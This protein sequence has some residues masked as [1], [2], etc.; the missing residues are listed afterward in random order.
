M[1]RRGPSLK[2]GQDKAH[3]GKDKM[4]KVLWSKYNALK[5]RV[6]VREGSDVKIQQT[7]W[8]D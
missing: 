7:L 6:K 8:Y 3:K 4:R 2:D 1:L 5:L